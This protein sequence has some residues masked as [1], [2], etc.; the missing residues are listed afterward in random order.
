MTT[1]MDDAAKLAGLER[2][3]A[4]VL[5]QWKVTAAN[6]EKLNAEL[7]RIAMD[8]CLEKRRLRGVVNDD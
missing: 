7:F 1:L 4:G 5:K 3:Y 6:A 8:I 2:R